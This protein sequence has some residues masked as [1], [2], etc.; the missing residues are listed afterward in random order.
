MIISFS[1]QSEQ[2]ASSFTDIYDAFIAAIL[3]S[4]LVAA[5]AITV[6][7]RFT[8]HSLV[9]VLNQICIAFEVL[10]CGLL[11]LILAPP[12]GFFFIVIWALFMLLLLLYYGFILALHNFLRNCALYGKLQ[13][14]YQKCTVGPLLQAA[15]TSM[16]QQDGF[17]ETS[18]NSNEMNVEPTAVP[19]A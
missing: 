12:F 7:A 3:I 13:N 8:N 1:M 17:T 9:P 19:Q 6:Q 14:F 4:T 10:A 16:D 5:A 18:K 11:L 2:G 15:Q